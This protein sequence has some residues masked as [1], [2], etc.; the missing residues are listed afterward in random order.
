MKRFAPTRRRL[1]AVALAVAGA[2]TLTPGAGAMT[3]TAGRDP[4]LAKALDLLDR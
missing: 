2:T 3:A 1:V 4:G